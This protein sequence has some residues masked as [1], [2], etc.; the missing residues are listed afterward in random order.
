MGKQVGSGSCL[1][2]IV[3]MTIVSE[4]LQ[5]YC[6]LLC[7][8]GTYHLGFCLILADTDHRK[9]M[10]FLCLVLPGGG[11]E[12]CHLSGSG[13]C[14][15]ESIFQAASCWWGL[16]WILAGVNFWQMVLLLVFLL[17][18]VGWG[19]VGWG[20]MMLALSHPLLFVARP[21]DIRV[22]FPLPP[23]LV[24]QDYLLPLGGSL[25]NG[26]SFLTCSCPA[27]VGRVGH[28]KLLGGDT[29][30]SRE[31]WVY[32]TLFHLDVNHPFAQH[33]HTVCYLTLLTE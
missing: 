7:S 3:L 21:E 22:V 4:P 6:G 10:C 15:P 11:Q 30:W 19:G 27:C 26:I 28:L 18:T 9:K 16:N 23:V 1:W 33:I 17:L 29:V 2:F 32:V 12:E 8:F 13:D 5:C 24:E 25:E 14:F 31:K 20:Q